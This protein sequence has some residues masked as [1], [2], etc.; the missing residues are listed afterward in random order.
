MSP[1]SRLTPPGNR[2]PPGQ[3][4]QQQQG[5]NMPNQ[6]GGF[7]TGMPNTNPAL[8]PNNPPIQSQMQ[9]NQPSMSNASQQQQQQQQQISNAPMSPMSM[10]IQQ[11]PQQPRWN[12]PQGQPTLPPPPPPPHG[13]KK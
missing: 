1:L 3:Q 10:S 4:Q 9:Q 2:I 12:T 13:V 5:P 6:M 7:N 11:Q 8:R